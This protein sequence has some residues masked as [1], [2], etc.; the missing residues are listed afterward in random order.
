[1][2]SDS[3]V[4][5]TKTAPRVGASGLP[6]RKVEPTLET[7]EFWDA[8]AKGQ[9]LLRKCD[10][11]STI[12]WYPRAFCPAC[13]SQ[14][15]SWVTSTG[16]GRIYSFSITRKGAGAWAEKGPYVIAYVELEEGPRVLTN[17][18]GCSVDA[19]SIG[20]AVNVVFD[21]TGEGLS[22]YRFAPADVAS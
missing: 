14:T 19:V 7:Q 4:G 10:D 5:Q 8:T 11:C 21:D 15:T 6:V 2:A 16:R 17:I 1:M 3:A 9:L 12:I 13:S 22:I 18:V 20:M